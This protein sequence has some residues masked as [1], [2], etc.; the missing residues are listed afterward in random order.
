MQVPIHDHAHCTADLL[1][2]AETSCAAQGAR[3]TGQRREVL[4]CVARSHQAVG[5]YDV[6]ER[7]AEQGARPAPIT[8][9][10]ALEFLTAHGLIHRIESRNAFV[11]CLHRHHGPAAA[12]L[13]CDGCGIVAELDAGEPLRHF[14]QAA[15]AVGFCPRRVMI[16]LSGT[17][18]VC[19][20][21]R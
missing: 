10:R 14:E 8:V 21:G 7:M 4:A 1:A 15:A 12:L 19:A 13:V 18:A 6:I 17:C 20:E 11:A 9:Y 16:E 2:R 3:L 5:A